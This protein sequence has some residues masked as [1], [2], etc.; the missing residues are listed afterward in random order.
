MWVEKL[1]FK[2]YMKTN[3]TQIFS[4]IFF[5]HWRYFSASYCHLHDLSAQHGPRRSVC[6]CLEPVD[7]VEA[8]LIA[9]ANLNT[10][11]STPVLLSSWT[12]VLILGPEQCFKNNNTNLGRFATCCLGDSTSNPLIPNHL[13][14]GFSYDSCWD[15]VL[16]G[17]TTHHAEIGN[18]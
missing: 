11:P 15:Y 17:L 10:R 3:S 9:V 8:I 1:N 12:W 18:M 7:A 2:T 14:H 4:G 13:Y 6:C 5:R 16:Q